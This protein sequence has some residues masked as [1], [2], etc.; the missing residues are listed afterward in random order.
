MSKAFTP[1]R[2]SILEKIHID[3]FLL[4]SLLCLML[5]GL[6]TIYSSGGQDWDLVNRQLVRLGLAITVMVVLAQVP[7]MLYQ[8]ASIYFYVV[9]VLM[10]IAV[11][12]VGDMG[13]GAQRWLDFGFIRFQ[14]S[15]ILKL[16]VPLMVAWYISRKGLPPRNCLVV[17][18]RPL[19]GSF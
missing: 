8:R 14:P 4:F 3:G 6:L 13:K 15:D 19:C 18:L 7:I 5:V 12:L 2:R 9:G 16:A 1:A 10:L 11:L 17:H